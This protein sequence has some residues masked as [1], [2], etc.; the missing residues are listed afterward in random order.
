MEMYCGVVTT[1]TTQQKYQ[2]QI[3]TLWRYYVCAPVRFIQIVTTIGIIK[4]YIGIVFQWKEEK[5]SDEQDVKSNELP[6]R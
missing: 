2:R 6:E 3:P 5:S 1:V 4:D